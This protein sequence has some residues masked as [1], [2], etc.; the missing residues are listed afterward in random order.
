MNH[1][2]LPPILRFTLCHT[3]PGRVRV[4]VFQIKGSEE[5]AQALQNW[6][7][8]QTEVQEASAITG[9]IVRLYDAATT[10][11]NVILGREKV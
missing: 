11:F 10:S 7:T 6:L 5:R 8:G 2:S 3:I 9:S 1:Q 4:K